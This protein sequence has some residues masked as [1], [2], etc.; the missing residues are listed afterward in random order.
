ML[1]TE[2]RRLSR[3]DAW[4][5]DFWLLDQANGSGDQQNLAGMLQLSS[6]RRCRRMNY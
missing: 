6:S 2:S 5:E 3:R 1:I 4:P